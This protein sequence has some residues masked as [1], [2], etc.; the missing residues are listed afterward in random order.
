MGTSTISMVI[1]HSYV[2]LLEGIQNMARK[3]WDVFRSERS[4]YWILK[5]PPEGHPKKLAE[6]GCLLGLISKDVPIIEVFDRRLF[7][8]LDGER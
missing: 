8:I 2:K 7:L 1:F 6:T 5:F 4:M 3:I